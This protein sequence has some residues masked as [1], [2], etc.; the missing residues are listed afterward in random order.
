MKMKIRTLTLVFA[1]AL[2]MSFGLLGIPTASAITWD[3]SQLI[4][5]DATNRNFDSNRATGTMLG[6]A[7]FSDT[8]ALMANTPNVTLFGKNG[9]GFGKNGAGDEHVLGLANDPSGENE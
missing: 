2:G 5:P 4:G 3:F 8:T 1:C 6:A 7:G 9:A